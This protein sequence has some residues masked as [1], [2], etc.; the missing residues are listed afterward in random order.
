MAIMTVAVMTL[1]FSLVFWLAGIVFIRVAQMKK[2]KIK[3]LEGDG[4]SEETKAKIKK[5][6][7]NAKVASRSF[8]YTSWILLAFAVLAIAL[9][10]IDQNM[11]LGLFKY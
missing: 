3:G 9:G 5:M 6:M 10:L 1:I 2:K 8:K 11:R 7:F 4:I